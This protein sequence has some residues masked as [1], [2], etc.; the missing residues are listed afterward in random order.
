MKQNI[1]TLFEIF[2]I[3][4][5][6]LLIANVPA[7]A[8]EKV[9]KIETREIVTT[10]GIYIEDVYL[11]GDTDPV[12]LHLLMKEE[13][14][15]EEII[16]MLAGT[17][18]GFRTNFLTPENQNLAMFYA[19]DGYMVVG[20]DYP[21]TLIDFEPGETYNNMKNWGIDKHIKDVNDVI[22]VS[23]EITD[24]NEYSIV[25]H[26]LGGIL[27]LAYAS[28]Y[29]CDEDIQSIVVLEAGQFNPETE[30]DMVESAEDSYYSALQ[31]IDDGNYV[32]LEMLGF[33]QIIFNAK[34]DPHGDSG[35]QNPFSVIDE[36]FTN[37]EFVLFTLIYTNQLPG[38]WHF[39][40]GFCSGNMTNGLY[41]SPIDV[42]YEVGLNG[43]IY[44]MAIERDF[45]AWMGGV[46]NGYMIEYDT[47]QVPVMWINTV[48]GM[49][50]R[51]EYT[52]QKIRDEGN[53]EV[54]F[55]LIDGGHVDIIY[56]NQEDYVYG[57][58]EMY[59]H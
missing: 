55:F 10:R 17:G 23:Q 13:E 39:N 41:Y 58:W 59:L 6:L 3:A 42:M 33:A 24:I 8:D 50:D 49:G 16:V 38:N 45:Y 4:C 14:S 31:D 1:I 29:K 36:N 34:I 22:E 46:S 9:N 21:E 27:S 2:G 28:K 19:D 48:G 32:E 52:A 20:I 11:I 18:L 26:S 51:G 15:P 25:G 47:I 37:E 30:S 43:T 44:P 54:E 57:I 12:G 5:L 53:E 56:G 40:Q 7:A 35:I